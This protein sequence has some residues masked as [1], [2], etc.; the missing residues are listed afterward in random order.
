[1]KAL[2][3]ENLMHEISGVPGAE[4]LQQIGSVEIDGTGVMPSVR[5]APLLEAPLTI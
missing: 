2:F 3:A 4:L 5:A 1:M